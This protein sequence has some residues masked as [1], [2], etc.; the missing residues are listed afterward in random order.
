VTLR[1]RLTLWYTVV[2]AAALILFSALVFLSLSYS[3][4]EEIDSTLSQTADEILFASETPQALAITM[5]ALDLTTNVYVQVWDDRGDMIW[6]SGNTP[7]VEGAFDPASLEEQQNV[8]TRRSHGNLNLRVLTVPLLSRSEGRV[9]GYLQLAGSLETVDNTMRTLL[10]ILSIGGVLVLATA[11]IVGFFTAQAA[12][13]P[14]DQVT[15]T[16][17]QITRADDLSRRIPHTGP[18]TSEDGRLILAFNETLER[19]EGL[20]E[21]QRRFLADVSH[22][23]RTPLTTIRGNVDLIRHMGEA[24]PESLDAITSEVDRMT[25]MVRDLLL[26]AQAETGKLPLAQDVVEL[27][28]LM[29]EVF[30]QAKVLAGDKI[31]LQIGHEDQA[32]VRGDRDRLKQVMLNLLANALENTP[33]DGEVTLNLICA[34]DW[35]KF[36]V[37]DNGRGISEQEMPDIFERF[38]RTDRSRVRKASGGAGLGLSIAFWITKSH[39]GRIEVDSKEGVGTTFS[40]W[41]PRLGENCA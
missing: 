27:D 21:T 28:T 15:E 25:R 11:A 36:S 40:V 5:R 23:L 31:H 4:T 37:A 12:L 2:L 41:L 3:L 17:L 9:I 35:A 24:D 32:R 29:L 10:L 6:R 26:L 7:D 20:F 38:Y 16:A 30:R 19:L 18:P 1:A 13:Q 39:G 34:G 14:I 22:E 8:F 33:Q